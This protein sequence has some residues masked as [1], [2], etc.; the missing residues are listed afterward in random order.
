MINWHGV[1]APAGTPAEIIVRLN[2]E[3]VKALS[4]T[5]VRA[6]LTDDGFEVIGGSPEAFARFIQ[7]EKD[8]WAKVVANAKIPQQ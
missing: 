4:S 8:K 2:A 1:L 7:S 6:R 3:F 5:E